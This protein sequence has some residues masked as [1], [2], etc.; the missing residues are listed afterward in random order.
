MQLRCKHCNTEIPTDKISPTQQL[1]SCPACDAVFGIEGQFEARLVNSIPWPGTLTFGGLKV[2]ASEKE[3]SITRRWFSADR[4]LLTGFIGLAMVGFV[5]FRMLDDEY[6]F[7]ACLIP[8][9]WVGLGMFYYALTG[10]VNS[11]VIRVNSHELSLKHGPLPFGFNRQISVA[12]L[13][14]LYTK[15]KT[16]KNK[17]R[18]TY[19]YEIHIITQGDKDKTILRGIDKAPQAVYLEQ[20]IERFLGIPDQDIIGG[21][22]WPKNKA[23]QIDWRAWKAFAQTHGFTFTP[24]T[25][26]EGVR[27]SGNYKGFSFGMMAFHKDWESQA[28]TYTLMEMTRPDNIPPA[29]NPVLTAKDVA[30]IFSLSNHGVKLKGIVETTEQG[31]KLTYMQRNLE[32]NSSHLNVALETLHR[33]IQ[34]YPAMLASGGQFIPLLHPMATDEK[35]PLRD[36]A[37]QLVQ[38]IAPTTHHLAQ[39][40]SGLVC[41]HCLLNFAEHKA[42]LSRFRVV[43]YYGCQQCH[44]S[45]EYFEVRQVIAVL[46]QK[47]ADKTAYDNG[48]LRINW[49]R[50]R[51]LF[52]FNTV[53]IINAADEDVERFAVQ[54]GNDTDPL[55]QSHYETM[56]CKVW[57]NCNLSENTMRI[58]RRIFGSIELV[59]Q[60]GQKWTK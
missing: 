26:V 35:H 57:A 51:H 37:Q 25:M 17:N 16:H 54:V 36:V 8:H 19:S 56:L 32:T 49:M 34:I 3:L 31:H 21:V 42:D 41:R 9:T 13:K 22:D 10:I 60:G 43:T 44:R 28:M 24:G 4:H 2:E 40:L 27:V 11:T 23:N 52:N 7:I 38:D 48:V 50:H 1:I 59:T 46:D 12:T 29:K 58:L 33:L 14:Q 53:E 30:K 47:T 5:L 55:R 45:T 20:E 39:A 18:T 6:F 15:Q